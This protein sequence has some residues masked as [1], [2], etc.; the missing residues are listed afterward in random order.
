MYLPDVTLHEPS[1]L[2]DAAAMLARFGPKARV[3]AGGTDLVVDLKTR[4]VAA[5]HII[6]LGRIAGL[7]GI[8][9]EPAGVGGGL[10]GRPSGGL[11]IGALTTVGE[12]SRSPLLTGRYA[13]ILDATRDMAATQVRNMATV[14]GNIAGGVPCADLPPILL[15]MG[16]SVVIASATGERTVPLDT[17]FVGPRTTLLGEGE[18][19]TAV[20]VPEPTPRSG[21][22]Y[23]RFALRDGN[24]IAVASVA[25]GLVLGSDGAIARAGLALGAVAP[26]PTPVRAVAAALVGRTLDQ[27][28]DDATLAAVAAADPISDVRGSADYRRE[29][30][31][32]LTRRALTAALARA[33]GE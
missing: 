17:F 1:T 29:L 33:R 10:N 19:L 12:L 15:V 3:M 26:I 28:M 18:L 7:R 24:A 22:A 20:V 23:A 32:V 21:A 9:R 27:G 11:R 6:S 4:R 8:R 14:G 2:A 16:A 31:R 25:A 13:P 5:E 30:V